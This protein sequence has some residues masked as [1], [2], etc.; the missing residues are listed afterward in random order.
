MI[1]CHIVGISNK[2]K[3]SFISSIKLLSDN[4]IIL[5]IDDIS[6]RIIFQK[7]FSLIYDK[8]LNTNN[9]RNL[10]TELGLIWKTNMTNEINKF[11]DANN[12]KYIIIIGL[13]TF[14]LDLR[15]K[16]NIVDNISNKFFVSINNNIYVKQ[17]IEYNID[18]YKTDIIDGKFPLNYLDF[19]FLKNQRIHIQDI[20]TQKNYKFKT[21][22]LIYNWIKTKINSF[23]NSEKKVW[24]AS[25]NRYENKLNINKRNLIAYQDKSLALMSIFPKKLIK[26]GIT[27][28]DSGELIPVIKELLP[29]A[30][31][32]FNKPC[33]LYEC[34]ANNKL[35][36]YRYL[37][38]DN[39]YI[40][41]EYISNIYNELTSNNVIFQK[42]H[43]TDTENI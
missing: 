32:E 31:N 5:D 12:S 42:Y 36:T 24:I 1:I 22:D 41:R 18:H 6:K 33:Y 39:N 20:Y 38:T 9:R 19:D 29:N 35:D 13:I 27:F 17:L 11:I 37:L 16:L 25:F 26:R 40:N 15:I 34:V 14:F 23:N 3:E 7:E 28:D 2:I 4:I 30:F 43:L 8:Y 21:Y 10:L